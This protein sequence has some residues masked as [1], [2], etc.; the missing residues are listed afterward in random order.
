MRAKHI[1][2]PTDFSSNAR[3]A[4]AYAISL[5]ENEECV[6]YVLNAFEVGASGLSSTMGKAKKTRLYRAIKEESEFNTTAL[7]AKLKH[8]NQNP[9]HEFKSLSIPDSLL[10]AI[11][12]T[13]ID[14]N[15]SYVFMGTKGSSAVKEVFMGSNTVSVIK[16]IDFCRLVAVPENY[17]FVSPEQIAFATNFE[18]VS[19]KVELNPL[20]D[21]AK[22]CDS[23]IIIVHVDMGKN[24]TSQQQTCKNILMKRLD[25]LPHRFEEVEGASKISDAIQSY[26]SENKDIGMIAMANYWHSFFERLTKENVINRIVFDTE[27]PFLIFPLIDP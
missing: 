3:N 25:G 2:L 13:V 18:H 22:L 24:L 10:N 9:I 1:L 14:N 5:F 4:I 12:K 27:V 16:H 6:F 11:G 20:I 19:S 17:S 26:I 15:I 8:K 23:E 21:L 7:V